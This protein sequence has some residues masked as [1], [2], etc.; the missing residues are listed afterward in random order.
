MQGWWWNK[1][2]NLWIRW[3]VSSWRTC[4]WPLFSIYYI[5]MYVYMYYSCIYYSCTWSNQNITYLKL[6]WLWWCVGWCD[7][8]SCLVSNVHFNRMVQN[9]LYDN[10][11][12]DI[13]WHCALVSCTPPQSIGL[14]LGVCCSCVECHYMLFYYLHDRVL[15][16]HDFHHDSCDYYWDYYGHSFDFLL[17]V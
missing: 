15:F 11:D 3:C 16:H 14:F 8:V 9:S 5:R 2:I 17:Q 13:M 7:T 6:V 4:L 10:M 1:R 12:I